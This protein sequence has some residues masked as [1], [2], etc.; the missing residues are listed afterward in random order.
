MPEEMVEITIQ[1]VKALKGVDDLFAFA[2]LAAVD[3]FDDHIGGDDVAIAGDGADDLVSANL[4]VFFS[5]KSGEAHGLVRGGV[6]PCPLI[7]GYTP[8][9]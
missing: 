9:V 8:W 6:A 7:M 2:A 4:E 5:E 1:E 3:C